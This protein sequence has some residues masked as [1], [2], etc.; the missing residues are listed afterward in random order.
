M[1]LKI[2]PAW[3]LASLHG[4]ELP[5]QAIIKKNVNA[6]KREY[7]LQKHKAQR[8]VESMTSYC[9]SLG[10]LFKNSLDNVLSSSNTPGL[11]RC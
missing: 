4:D 3:A 8:S 1:R 10:N 2:V 11:L 7:Y 5:L 9:N 6:F